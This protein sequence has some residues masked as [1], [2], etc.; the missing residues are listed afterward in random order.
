ME[1]RKYVMMDPPIDEMRRIVG[2]KFLLTCLVSKRAKDLN[3]QYLMG[4]PLDKDPKVIAIAADE[5]YKGK[6]VA[7]KFN[8]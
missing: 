8:I 2:N 7:G 1:E 4:E 6:V 5:I 3:N